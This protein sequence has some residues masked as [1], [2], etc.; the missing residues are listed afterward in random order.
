MASDIT[1]L[2]IFSLPRSG[3]TLLQRI[4]GASDKVSTHSEPWILLPLLSA[5]TNSEFY[6]EYGH[7]LYRKA[8][9]DVIPNLEGGVE[10]YRH[11]TKEYFLAIYSAL[12]ENGSIYY[13]DKTPRYHLICD[14][15]M[16]TFPDAKFIFLWRSPIDII[17]SIVNTWFGGR[18]KLSTFE[19]DLNKG[20][21]NLIQV[22][23]RVK[24]NPNVLSVKYEDL[25]SK[26]SSE[27]EILKISSFL[28]IEGLSF[29]NQIQLDGRLGD[30]PVSKTERK[31]RKKNV[32]NSWYRKKYIKEVIDQISTEKWELIGYSKVDLLR[33]VQEN[34]GIIPISFS[35]VKL[36]IKQTVR[37]RII[38]ESKQML[39]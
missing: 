7:K 6:T 35:D 10:A 31:A 29:N 21:K 4:L 37:K 25:I 30:I 12:S 15:I 32:I 17:S 2:F 28:G 33:S 1:P 23:N 20:L 39:Y 34:S 38:P 26:N 8:F 36:I 3:S 16:K 5:N 19:I 11:Y 9:D 22:Y 14:E 27:V 18:W 13:L 24:E